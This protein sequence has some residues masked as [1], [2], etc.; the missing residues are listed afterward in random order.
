MLAWAEAGLVDAVQYDIFG[1]GFTP[2][3]KLGR[4]LDRWGVL[5]A[6][7][8]YGGYF[9]NFVT[10]HLAAAIDNFALVEWDEAA[11]PEVDH[12]AYR[13][14]DGHVLLPTTPGFGLHLD[15]ERFE[16]A[17]AEGGYRLEA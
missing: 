2:W 4:T 11:V 5:T 6:P 10:G 15:E 8:H 14:V 9:G 13:V 3:L 12:T 17:V 1:Y 16:Q 7:H